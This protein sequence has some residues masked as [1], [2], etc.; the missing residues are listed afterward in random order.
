M[1]VIVIRNTSCVIT[2]YFK[3]SATNILKMF[4]DICVRCPPD[5]T[6]I[7]KPGFDRAKLQY[8]RIFSCSGQKAPRQVH[9]VHM[10]G[11]KFGS[12][13][14]EGSHMVVGRITH[15]DEVSLFL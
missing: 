6:L 14:K 15:K 9:F 2:F 8:P 7:T 12:V 5:R 13:L 1:K 3:V 11:P 4:V 10:Y